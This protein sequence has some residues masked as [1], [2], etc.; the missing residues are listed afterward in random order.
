MYH[1]L[2]ISFFIM[3][4]YRSILPIHTIKLNDFESKIA[5]FN[6]LSSSQICLPSNNRTNTIYSN[7]TFTLHVKGNFPKEKSFKMETNLNTYI[8]QLKETIQQRTGYHR[9]QQ[10]LQF[11]SRTYFDFHRNLQD[12]HRLGDYRTVKNNTCEYILRVRK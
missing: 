4:I 11:V 7:S 6:S 9:D 10:K 12:N 3:I 5:Y 1:H 2:N 8:Y